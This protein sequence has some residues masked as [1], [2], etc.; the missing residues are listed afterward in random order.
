M[1]STTDHINEGHDQTAETLNHATEQVADMITDAARPAI[2]RGRKQ[3]DAARRRRI[4]E[5]ATFEAV[6]W[7]AEATIEGQGESMQNRYDARPGGDDRPP[8]WRPQPGEVL[9]GVIDHY[10]LSDTPQG[11]VRTVIVTEARTGMWVSLRLASTSLLAL[12]A[13]Q[14]PHPGE[15]IDVRYRWKAPDH[16]YQRWRLRVDRPAPLELSPLGGEVSDEAPWHREPRVA[17]AVAELTQHP[18]EVV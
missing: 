17:I 9:A 2:T 18:Q 3:G 15:W 16:G 12:F 14:Q 4:A 6:P 11:L 1:R 13:Q 10:S 8:T 5:D 7:M